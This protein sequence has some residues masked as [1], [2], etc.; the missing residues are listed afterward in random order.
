MDSCLPADLTHSLG[1]LNGP[2]GQFKLGDWHPIT[3][4]NERR[5]AMSELHTQCLPGGRQAR[6]DSSLRAAWQIS[7]TWHFFAPQVTPSC[8]CKRPFGCFRP[9]DV[10][11]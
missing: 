10:E 11:H 1:D 3:K 9:L 4:D 6:C 2:S 7:A 8:Q 5:D